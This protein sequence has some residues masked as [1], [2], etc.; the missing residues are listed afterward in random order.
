ML[1]ANCLQKA[2]EILSSVYVPKQA[3][4]FEIFFWDRVRNFFCKQF[5]VNLSTTNPPL[6]KKLSENVFHYSLDSACSTIQIVYLTLIFRPSNICFENKIV[7]ER[8]AKY[9]NWR[10]EYLQ[11]AV[12][13]QLT[14]KFSYKSVNKENIFQRDT[15]NSNY[16]IQLSNFH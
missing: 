7:K 4:Q 9:V 6:P 15:A 2:L 10:A 8:R 3:C 12:K 16:S 5:S 14:I 11:N 1:S 13:E